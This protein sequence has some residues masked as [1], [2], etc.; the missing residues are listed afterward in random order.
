MY[1]WINQ[2]INHIAEDCMRPTQHDTSNYGGGGVVVESLTDMMAIIMCSARPLGALGIS[3]LLSLQVSY[4]GEW[5][6][7]ASGIAVEK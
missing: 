3:S 6:K 4:T 5:F 1:E 2:S 7:K